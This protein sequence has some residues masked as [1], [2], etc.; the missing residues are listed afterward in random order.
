VA[1]VRRGFSARD[2]PSALETY[3][4]RT[5]R[6]MAV[7]SRAAKEKNPFPASL[8]LIAEALTHF[9]DHCAIGHAND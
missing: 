3:V 5:A 6:N 9:A 4:A 2:Q 8:E 1:A 7:P